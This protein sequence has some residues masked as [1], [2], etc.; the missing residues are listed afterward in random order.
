MKPC[1]PASHYHDAGVYAREQAMFEKLWAFAGFR[2]HLEKPDDYVTVQVGRKSV[3][4]QNFAGELRAFENVCSHRFARLRTQPRGNGI[5]QCPYHAWIYN[6]A[7]VPEVIPKKPRFEGMTPEVRA[8]LALAPWRVETCGSLVFIR[9]GTDGPT[10]REYLGEV[11]AVVEEM[12][13]A[14]GAL[15]DENILE[16]AA[17]WK[18]VVENTLEGYHVGHVHAQT[19][20][21]LKFQ[22]IQMKMDGLHTAWLAELGEEF[23]KKSARVNE[24]FE[25]RP[26]KITGY[27][28]WL[29]FPNVTLATT[30][31]TSFALQYIQPLAPGRTR[32]ASYVFGTRLAEEPKG[33]QL[34]LAQTLYEVAV[35]FNRKVFDEDKTVVE[36][37]QLGSE[38]TRQTGILS[39]DEVRVHHFQEDYAR[40]LGEL[41]G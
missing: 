15:L 26:Y 22:R 12:T 34:T 3:F 13:G 17:N 30:F 40:L 39:E 37:V 29:L 21:R 2:Q 16:I 27:A 7:G 4:V 31:G 28:H 36:F 20:D 1:F 32:F 23:A 5:V 19:F 14:F 41:A 10:L 35:A 8:A 9:A 6:S 18:I 11:F 38:Q 24:F 33:V 25:S